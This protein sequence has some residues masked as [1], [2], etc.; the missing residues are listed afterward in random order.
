MAS[1]HRLSNDTLNHCH[2]RHAL[3]CRGPSLTPLDHLVLALLWIRRAARSEANMSIRHRFMR[4]ALILWMNSLSLVDYKVL[5]WM[6]PTRCAMAVLMSPANTSLIKID[7]LD[8]GSFLMVIATGIIAIHASN[9]RLHF[10]WSNF[11][12]FESSHKPA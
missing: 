8:A 5:A 2:D 9:F 10:S 7:I 3:T 1:P 12:D 6:S 4:G 11:P